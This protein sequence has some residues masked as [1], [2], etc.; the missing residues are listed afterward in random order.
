MPPDVRQCIGR[1]DA[2]G[3]G[4]TEAAEALRAS[5]NIVYK[6][7]AME[8]LSPQPPI[9]EEREGPAIGR[10]APLVAGILVEDRSA[11]RKQRHSAKRIFGRLVGGEG[12]TGSYPTVCRFVREWKPARL[13]S[14]GGGLLELDWVP[15][16]MQADYG[17]FACALAGEGI[18][19][20]LLAVTFPHLNARLCIAMM[21]GKAECFCEGLVEIFEMAGRIPRTAVL[22]NATEAGRMFFGKVTESRL[23]SQPEA[24]YRFESRFRNPDSG[25]EKGSVGNAAGLLRRDPLVPAPSAPALDALNSMLLA[26]CRRRRR[27]TATAGPRSRGRRASDAPACSRSRSSGGAR[28]S[29]SWG[30]WGPARPTCSRRTSRRCCRCPGRASTP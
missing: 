27:L 20:K 1:M 29:C 26:G 8:D 9:A 13:Q 19:L 11:P 17:I 2:D 28:A 14:P 21:C 22:D 30:M 24:H 3:A 25:S 4:P 12:C 23:F 5:R 18:G 6:Y 15:G 10:Y 16:T 7:S